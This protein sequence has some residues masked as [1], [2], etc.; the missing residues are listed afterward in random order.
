MNHCSKIIFLFLLVLVIGSLGS[1]TAGAGSGDEY[2]RA[3]IE[4]I[5]PSSVGIDEEFTV[6]IGLENCGTRVP[7]NITF[8]IIS[9][10]RTS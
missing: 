7:E 5:S 9:I 10:P 6:G 1:N 4:D 3:V 2:L 8:E